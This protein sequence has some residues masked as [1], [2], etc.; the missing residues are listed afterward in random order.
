MKHFVYVAC[1]VAGIMFSPTAAEAGWDDDGHIIY[2]KQ[3]RQEKYENCRNVIKKYAVNPRVTFTEKGRACRDR[4]GAWVMMTPTRFPDEIGEVFV[5]RKGRLVFL[6]TL[7]PRDDP[8]YD[9]PWVS[10]FTDNDDAR[11]PCPRKD[12]WRSAEPADFGWADNKIH[13]KHS[14]HHYFD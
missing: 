10:Y 2:H 1:L 7:Y 3:D 5:K 11:P 12:R 8:Y 6:G 4:F 14:N 13:K 9:P